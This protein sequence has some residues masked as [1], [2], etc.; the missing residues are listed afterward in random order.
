MPWY[1]RQFVESEMI[2]LWKSL[3]SYLGRPENCYID[4][5]YFLI[6]IY[7]CFLNLIVRSEDSVHNC[8]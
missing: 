1:V 3:F 5:S 2:M 4:F 7:F 6:V 8:L